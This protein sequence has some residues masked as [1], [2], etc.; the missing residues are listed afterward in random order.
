MI[1][2]RPSLR[3]AGKVYAANFV[4]CAIVLP[5]ESSGW[6]G[7]ATAAAL[8]T[9]ACFFS[10]GVFGLSDVALRQREQGGDKA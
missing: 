7:D 2:D 1:F 10:A 4:S 5:L 3:M 9:V 8:L 6:I